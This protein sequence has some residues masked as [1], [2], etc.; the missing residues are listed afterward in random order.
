MKETKKR[1]KVVFGLQENQCIWMKAGVVNFKLCQNSYDCTSCSF[2]KAMQVAIKE[3]GSSKSWRKKMLGKSLKK[4]RHML[5]GEVPF[6]LCSYA[7]DCSNCEFDQ[8]LEELKLRGT[9]RKGEM[10]LVSGFY[11][12]TD[13]YYNRSHIWIKPEYGGFI[14]IGMDDFSWHLLG[15]LDEIR[16]PDI[17][18]RLSKGKKAWSVRREEK[19][20]P[21]NAPFDA[22]VVARNH[23]AMID[24]DRAKEDPYGYG[25]LLIVDS[26]PNL[27]KSP[28]E[29]MD[30]SEAEAWLREEAAALDS[31]VEKLYQM[32]LA[33]TGGE[34]PQD[35]YGNL[36]QVEWDYLIEK[37]FLRG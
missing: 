14:R 19:V 7:Y 9:S 26:T 16:L 13:R 4:C 12:A 15:F 30:S 28:E 25:W 33:A 29:L 17:G 2:D 8:M 1:K 32:P 5:S 18:T 21:F 37:F 35:I 22:I 20:A 34:R 11:F 3:K 31:L 6:R 23:K 10:K 36:R 24:P 27:K